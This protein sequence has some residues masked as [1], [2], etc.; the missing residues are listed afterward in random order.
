MISHTNA[1]H[2]IWNEICDG[3]KLVHSSSLSVIQERMPAGTAETRHKHKKVQQ[4]FY[5]LK[6][7]LTLEVEGQTITLQAQQGLEVLP[8]QGHQ[9]KNES[10][11]V[12]EFLVISNGISREDREEV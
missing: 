3:W 10:D 5:V 6:G 11:E 7:I 12:V 1:P 4:F 8:E 2:Y 9:A